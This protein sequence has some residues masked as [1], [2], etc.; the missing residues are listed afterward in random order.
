MYSFGDLSIGDS[1]NTMTARWIKVGYNKAMCT[2]S[3]MVKEGETVTSF[4]FENTD[5]LPLDI[6]SLKRKK[7][8]IY[9]DGIILGNVM[10]HKELLPDNPDL[11]LVFGGGFFHL[12]DGKMY[13]FGESTDFGPFNVE[14]VKTIPF[15]SPIMNRVERIII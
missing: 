8:I 6:H 12:Q 7:F 15:S 9:N 1:F 14:M 13:F 10:R 3:G 5:I 2:I 11:S 4:Y